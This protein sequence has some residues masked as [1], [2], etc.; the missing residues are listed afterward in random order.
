MEEIVKSK[1]SFVEKIRL[2][3]VK[4]H[5]RWFGVLALI[6]V[7]AVVLIV[8]KASLMPVDQAVS[9]LVLRQADLPGTEE[10]GLSMPELVKSVETVE[11]LIATCMSEAGFEYIAA[12]FN[13]VRRA[14]VSDKSLPGLSEKQYVEQYGFGISTLYTGLSPQLSEVLTP[15]QMGLGQQNVQIFRNLSPADQVAYNRTLFGENTDATFAVAIETEDFRR[16][17]GCTRR[18]IEQVFTPEQLTVTYVNPKDA[19]IEQDPRMVAALAE[20]G[21]CMR[22]AGFNYKLE[23]E[24]EPDLKQRLYEITNGDPVESLSPDAQAALKELQGEE[25]ALAVATYN[26]ENRIISPVEDQVEHEL[27]SGRLG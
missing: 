12:D 14:M 24:I 9:R 5:G 2:M 17:G 20:F 6:P 8:N 22:A 16:T 13:T 7:V 27:Y 21:D 1:P 10:F 23:R 3:V 18:A 19:L 4:P 26:C 25:R 11:G 15:A